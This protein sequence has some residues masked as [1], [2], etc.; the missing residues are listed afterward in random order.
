MR[1]LVLGGTVF[2][3]R[4]V[5]EHAL[6]RGHEVTCVT[7]GRS[8]S[9][10][11]GARSVVLDRD[12]PNG[13]DALADAAYDAV[14]DVESLSVGRVRRA[15]AA[16]GD[17]AG[18]WTYVSTASVYADNRTPGQRAATA[19]LLPPA[20]EG[21]DG[22]V[23]QYGNLKVACEDAVREVVGDR[24]FVCRP[25][26]IV[27]PGDRSD[28]FGYWP[29]RLADAGPVLVPGD[30]ADLVQYVDV[31][32][33][34]SWIVRAA[35]ERLVATLDAICPPLPWGDLLDQIATAVDSHAELAWVPQSVLEAHDVAPWAGPDSLPLWL[36]RPEYAGFG[37][38]D[39]SDSLAAGLR[40]R[41]VAETALAA[42]AHERELGLDRERRAGLGRE[43]ERAVLAA[44]HAGTRRRTKVPRTT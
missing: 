3:S 14:V 39:V 32:D 21:T 40:I 18:H 37:A 6:G 5:A 8:G 17:R 16:L 44:Y 15:V 7:R 29:A 33:C 42:L 9:P 36:P 28:R 35:E 38:R 41:P 19:P 31:R 4:A 10:S 43:R 26:L 34:A 12:D 27:G 1:L 2:L 13:L 30:P 24:A 20:T 11:P 22:D 25:G 23:D